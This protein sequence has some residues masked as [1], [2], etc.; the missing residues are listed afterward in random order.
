MSTNL[1]A[2]KQINWNEWLFWAAIAFAIGEFMDAFSIADPTTG[3]VFAILVAAYAT[4][5]RMRASRFPVV[6]LLILSVLELAAL[7]FI[8]PHG[9]TPP[10]PWRSGLFIVLSATVA[11]LSV[12]SLI[13]PQIK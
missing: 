8:Y 5:F 3:I 10:A 12:R 6:I 1:S 7:I 4:W 9:S 11:I 2:K 13:H